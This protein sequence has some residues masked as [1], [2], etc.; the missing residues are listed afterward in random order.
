MDDITGTSHGTGT[1]GQAFVGEDKGTIF[2]NLHS[3][4]RAGF[5]A[6][7][8]TDAGYVAHVEAAG[9]LVGA[10]ND[11]GIGLYTKVDDTLGAG[12]VTGTATDALALV[13][14]CYAV[15]VKGNGAEAAHIHTGSAT[16]AAV[17]AHIGAVLSLLSTATA[18]AVDASNFL[19][20]LLF[21]DHEG[22]SFLSAF[23]GSTAE[24]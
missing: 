1:A 6:Q 15:G 19:G 24:R 3:P 17:V 13:N 9:I 2:R 8:A 18:V 10:E 14:L 22:A 4:G 20:E 16:C 5:F 21:N 11:D 12:T 23:V 7:A